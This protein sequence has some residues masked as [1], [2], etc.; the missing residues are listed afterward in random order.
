M[1]KDVLHVDQFSINGDN[2][3]GA[4]QEEILNSFISR[5]ET[6]VKTPFTPEEKVQMKDNAEVFLKEW[7]KDFYQFPNASD[8]FNN[9]ALGV[10][11]KSISLEFR[12]K[13]KEWKKYPYKLEQGQFKL[14]TVAIQEKHTT[15]TSNPF[16]STALEIAQELIKLV[17]R[18][19][20]E[21]ILNTDA[22]TSIRIAEAFRVLKLDGYYTQDKGHNLIP[23]PSIPFLHKIN[24]PKHTQAMLEA[25][26]PKQKEQ[27]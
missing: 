4:K 19:Q 16:Q 23:N 1:K 8:E 11:M 25:I 21:G 5:V 12:T 24:H 9:D 13:S 2:A 22:Q 14:D 17:E 18:A 15:Y 10:D 27:E 7:I 6:E 26:I 20:A 3:Q